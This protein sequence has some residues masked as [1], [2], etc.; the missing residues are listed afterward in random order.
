MLQFIITCF[1]LIPRQWLKT[2]SC[3]CQIISC[4]ANATSWKVKASFTRSVSHIYYG[5]VDCFAHYAMILHDQVCIKK[6]CSHCLRGWLGLSW[7]T[8]L[9][10]LAHATFYGKRWVQE[11]SESWHVHWASWESWHFC[12]SIKVCLAG[13]ISVMRSDPLHLSKEVMKSTYEL[14]I[15]L[16]VHAFCMRLNCHCIPW[17][18][19]SRW[20]IVAVL[21]VDASLLQNTWQ[22]D[23]NEWL[24]RVRVYSYFLMCWAQASVTYM[25]LIASTTIFFE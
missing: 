12:R 22:K 5:C 18:S 10:W 3:R 25:K 2:H 19:R 17:R 20:H 21:S 7:V 23:R 6:T 9:L 15:V 14:F 24:W 11:V 8:R 16:R 4:I 13:L 1:V